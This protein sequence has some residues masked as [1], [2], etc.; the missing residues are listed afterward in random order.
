MEPTFPWG[1]VETFNMWVKEYKWGDRSIANLNSLHLSASI[2][3]A[4][5]STYVMDTNAGSLD[6]GQD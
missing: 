1:D 5:L 3:Y 2:M 6:D 4:K